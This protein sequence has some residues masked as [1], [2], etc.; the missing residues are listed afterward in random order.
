[1]VLQELKP[2]RNSLLQGKQ[3]LLT[4]DLAL[5]EELLGDLAAPPGLPVEVQRTQLLQ[6]EAER[7]LLVLWKGPKP[8][9]DLT[10][11]VVGLPDVVD[12]SVPLIQPVLILVELLSELV[13]DAVRLRVLCLLRACGK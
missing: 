6:R 2:V 9:K 5:L 8:I 13:L 4:D 7:L 1:M 12:L 3:L 11:A 10:H